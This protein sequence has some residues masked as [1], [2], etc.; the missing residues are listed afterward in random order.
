MSTVTESQMAIDMALQGGLGIIHRYM[1]LEKQVEE[2]KKVK[3]FLQYIIESPYTIPMFENICDDINEIDDIIKYINQQKMKSKK[4]ISQT[5]NFKN[6][7]E[8]ILSFVKYLDSMEMTS[9]CEM[10]QLTEYKSDLM[11]GQT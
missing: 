6:K 1:T 3:R 7:I 2:V 8:M 10:V 9:T 11:C 4:F 5:E